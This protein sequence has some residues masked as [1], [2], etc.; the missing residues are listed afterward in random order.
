MS[1]DTAQFPELADIVA[2]GVLLVCVILWLN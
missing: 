1:Y 2:K